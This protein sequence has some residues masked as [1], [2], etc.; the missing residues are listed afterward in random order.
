M[1]KIIFLGVIALGFSVNANSQT[2][3]E[4]FDANS[5]EWTECAFES[6]NGSAI[7]D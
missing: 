2:F 1:K 6:S 3:K 7:I 5:L 4:T